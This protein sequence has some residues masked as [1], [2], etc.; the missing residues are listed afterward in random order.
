M[1]QW[2]I[3]PEV[4]IGK[5]FRVEKGSKLLAEVRGI[6][7]LCYSPQTLTNGYQMPEFR[8][9]WTEYHLSILEYAL[10]AKDGDELGEPLR[11]SRQKV[12][13]RLL[14]PL[15]RLWEELCTEWTF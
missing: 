14:A 5:A 11:F 3:W 10:I 8:A 4:L 1:N 6:G 15:L 12:Q 13:P 9:R 2:K 7:C